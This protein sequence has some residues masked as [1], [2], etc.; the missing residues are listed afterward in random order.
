[1]TARRRIKT[2]FTLI[3]L[4]TVIAIIAILAAIIFPIFGR[5]R[6]QV[7]QT[8]TMSQMHEI[9]R[10]IKLYFVDNGKYPAV[11]LGYAQ[12]TNGDFY[13]G[14]NEPTLPID[15]LTYRPCT[16]GAKY[17]MDKSQFNSPDNTVRNPALITSAVYP[18]GTPLADQTVEYTDTLANNIRC[19]SKDGQV[20]YAPR[21]GTAYFY[22]YD[23]YDVGPRLD[24]NGNIVRVNGQPVY[25]LHYSI[26]WTGE[27]PGP[28]DPPNQLK[29]PTAPEDSTVITWSTHQAAY[30]GSDKIPVLMLSGKVKA[31]PA[32]QFL[33]A[34][35]LNFRMN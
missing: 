11:L 33:Q 23:S 15:Q 25:E 2:G 16:V 12:K 4:L 6:A 10:N 27:I 18:V 13:L 1:M 20:W 24:A 32:R 7:R 21:T 3:E 5:V 8:T 22:P 34:G 19:T 31:V 14:G 35:P 9:Q 30:S 26:D 29:Y 17:N 28:N